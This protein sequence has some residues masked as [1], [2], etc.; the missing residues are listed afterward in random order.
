MSD[1]ALTSSSISEYYGSISS[2]DTQVP[3]IDIIDGTGKPIGMVLLENAKLGSEDTFVHENQEEN[4][5]M[6]HDI[7][8]SGRSVQL[9]NDMK[10]EENQV[11]NSSFMEERKDDM[12]SQ[13]STINEMVA[14]KG[15]PDMAIP[16]ESNENEITCQDQMA[17]ERPDDSLRDETDDSLRDETDDSLRDETDDS[18]REIKEGE[19]LVDSGE[20]ARAELQ[21][22]KILEELEMKTV[23]QTMQLIKD[24][25][26][27]GKELCSSTQ[28]NSPARSS[29]V[30]SS[31]K[32]LQGSGNNPD[33]GRHSYSRYDTVSYRK[34][35]KGNTKQR[36]DEFESMNL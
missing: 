35:R 18:L 7:S 15:A 2:E 19:E 17:A 13:E 30:S 8:K 22:V 12:T 23:D 14:G 9:P 32:V 4:R 5:K 3:I 1:E 16:V 28:E 31:A 11:E 26:K 27:N 21:T 25:G 10:T 6:A 20:K 33:I 36:V 29:F 24:H 34:I